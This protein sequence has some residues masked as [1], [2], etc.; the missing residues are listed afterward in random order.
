[1]RAAV[2]VLTLWLAACAG[3]PTPRATAPAEGAGRWIEA[4]RSAL[5]RGEV[6]R[7]ERWLE[8]AVRV[9]PRDPR[10]WRALAD[11]RQAQG[12]WEEAR[13]LRLRACRLEG[14]CR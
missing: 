9:A 14:G 2:V 8:Q 10:A 13:R 12:R 11:L 3:G 5:E 1:V 6:V 7:A 4:G